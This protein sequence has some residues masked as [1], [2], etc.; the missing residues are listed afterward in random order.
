MKAL[1]AAALLILLFGPSACYYQRLEA[2]RDGFSLECRP[3][4]GD[5]AD[6]EADEDTETEVAAGMASMTAQNDLLLNWGLAGLGAVIALI[7][8]TATHRFLHV[9]VLYLI[10]APALSL[11]AGS[12]WAGLLFQ[13]RMTYQTLNACF[14]TKA[15]NDL[16]AEQSGLLQYAV[17]V[18]GLFAVVCLAQIVLGLVDPAESDD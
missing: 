14:D 15:L 10:L 11:L 2:I 13:R 4:S 8:T 6:S 18:L 12:L 16:L 9:H 3:S 17:G 1:L 5:A 7:T